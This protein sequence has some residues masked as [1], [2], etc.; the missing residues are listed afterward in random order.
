MEHNLP[1]NDERLSALREDEVGEHLVLR[2]AW[3]SIETEKLLKLKD[4]LD[5]QRHQEMLR[6]AGVDEVDVEVRDDEEA[7]NIAD[8]PIPGLE[9]DP[10]WLAWEREALDPTKDL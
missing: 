2:A 9:D 6:R 8:N 7:R 4:K 1:L 10:E 5:R 3:K